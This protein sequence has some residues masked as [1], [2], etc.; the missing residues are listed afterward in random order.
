MIKKATKKDLRTFGIGLTVILAVLGT[1]NLLRGHNLYWYFYGVSGTALLFSLIFPLLIKPVYL[2]MHLFGKV[3]N[4]LVSHII[5]TILYFLV[6]TPTGIIKR[7]QKKSD[8][9]L[10][11]D[12]QRDS[13]WHTYDE[14]SENNFEK[15]F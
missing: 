8:I 12:I 11:I 13:Y 2:V 5:F 4:F 14:N 3:M 15:Q 6:L 1:I 9:E 10:D 7:L